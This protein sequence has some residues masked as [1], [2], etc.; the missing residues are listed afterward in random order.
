MG[1]KTTYT[2]KEFVKKKDLIV[3][4]NQE[5]GDTD[6]LICPGDF[7]LGIPDLPRSIK[8]F[9]G[10]PSDTG[11]RL[12]SVGGSLYFNGSELRAGGASNAFTTIAVGGRT[13]IVAD[14]SSDTLTFAEGTGITIT[15]DPAT[16][17]IT[18]TGNVGDITS[19]SAGTLLD[20]GNTTG[21]VTL[22]VDLTEATARTIANGDY[23]IFL[24]GGTTGIHAKG[25]IADFAT[26][27]A[28]NGL[29]A[30]SSVL[31]IDFSEFSSVT[32]THGDSLAT[33]D[34][35]GSTEQLTTVA[36]L[37]T[38]FAG[39]GL[40]TTNSVM[41]LDISELTGRVDVD[42]HNDHLAIEDSSDSSSTRKASVRDTARAMVETEDVIT[43][44]QMFL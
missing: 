14:S 31:A 18:I 10:A 5:S 13:N 37:A 4:V 26:L 35:N 15:T 17:T 43:A 1:I 27:F 34:S 38:L 21:D 19:V 16:D 42:P 40:S 36:S 44:M 20:G 9:D 2:K 7:Q 39:D 6:R 28:G 11:R 23:I 8:I 3:I 41:R 30:T 29:S 22:N 33:L 12:Y 25:N 24:D 32:P